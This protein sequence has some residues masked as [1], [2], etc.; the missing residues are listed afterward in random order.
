MIRRTIIHF[1][2]GFG[3]IVGILRLRVLCSI[4]YSLFAKIYTGYKAVR[5][6]KFG[7]SS[8]RPFTTELWG[9][10][11][12]EIGNNSTIGK[13]ISLTATSFY[14][15]QVFTP[16]IIIGNNVSIGDYSHI[17]AIHRI[18]IDDGVLTGR[19]VTITDNSHGNS[20]LSDLKTLPT[21]R[22]LSSKGGVYIGKNVWIGEKATILPNVRI[23]EGAIIA[24]N[25]VVTK[26]V[27]PYALVAGC[28]AKLIKTSKI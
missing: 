14:K 6:R 2:I 20:D 11:Y 16:K 26:D 18:I 27:P 19:F 4:L 22:V 23:G 12:I 24:A 8:F 3:K 13:G 17:T 25:A 15:G 1:F 7:E 10:K 21:N 28:P 9:E 5:F